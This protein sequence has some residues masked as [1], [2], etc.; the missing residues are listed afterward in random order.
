[1]AERER[2]VVQRRLEG[3]SLDA[4]ASEFGV[5]EE[6]VQHLMQRAWA[7]LRREAALVE[8]AEAG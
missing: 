8:L 3:W 1:M 2:L 7:H 5:T 4:I 6:R